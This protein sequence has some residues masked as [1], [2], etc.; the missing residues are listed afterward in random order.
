MILLIKWVCK[1]I[2]EVG[3][4]YADCVH[5]LVNASLTGFKKNVS[6]DSTCIFSVNFKT[7]L[8][9][10]RISVRRQSSGKSIVSGL[11]TGLVSSFR[12]DLPDMVYESMLD[13]LRKLTK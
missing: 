3:S 4:Y 5:A 1:Q 11:T 2:L 6:E 8:V 10:S 13:F 7:G 9:F 12:S